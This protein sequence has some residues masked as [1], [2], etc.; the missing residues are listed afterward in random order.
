MRATSSTS[1]SRNLKTNSCT[2]L[3]R[4]AWYK[5][6]ILRIALK[7]SRI[8]WDN[9]LKTILTYAIILMELLLLQKLN[10]ET[11]FIYM[12]TSNRIRD[13]SL[14]RTI[15]CSSKSSN[16]NNNNI[17]QT[18]IHQ[19]TQTNTGTFIS[20]AITSREIISLSKIEF[21]MEEMS[22]VSTFSGSKKA[23]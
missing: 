2:H 10:L 19:Y 9:Q 21:K 1:N 15:K 20:K 6:L 7:A 22:F 5:A 11:V 12:K 14:C 18:D 16:S 3:G 17:R 23:K 13:R 4:T 8:F